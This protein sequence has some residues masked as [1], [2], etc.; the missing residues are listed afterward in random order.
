MT[1]NKVMREVKYIISFI[2]LVF[3]SLAFLLP[4]FWMLSTAF[5]VPSQ[6]YLIPPKWIPEPFTLENFVKGWN[7]VPFSRYTI[8]TVII[9]ALA[10]IGTLFSSSLVAYGFARFNSRW[11]GPLFMVV[12][13]TLMLPSQVTLI[14]SYILFSKLKWLDT[15]LPLV[16]PAWLGGGSFNI[17]LLRQFFKGIPRELDQAAKIDGCNS[18]QIFYIILLPLIRTALIAVGVMS[19]IYYW[20]DFMGPLIYLKSE[21]KFTISIGLQFFNNSYGANKVNL[22]MAVS[23][24]TVIPMLILFFAAQRYFVQAITITG[25]KG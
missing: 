22:L 19:V 5:K 10:T 23:M 21:S 17:F 25:I 1:Y 6:I 18:F 20:N 11:N 16:V 13:A 7:Y 12:I 2:I 14:P 3:L 8:N 24:L 15:F 9:T 4:F